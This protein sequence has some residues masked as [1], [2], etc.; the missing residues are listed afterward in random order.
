MAKSSKKQ[1]QNKTKSIKDAKET[2][3]KH[4]E[5]K[6]EV[7]KRKIKEDE[8]IKKIQKMQAVQE[9]QEARD[10]KESQLVDNIKK[11]DKKKPSDP[12]QNQKSDTTSETFSDRSRIIYRESMD[13]CIIGIIREENPQLYKYVDAQLK[14]YATDDANLITNSQK[15]L[16]ATSNDG[17]MASSPTII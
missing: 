1:Q 15:L 12:V 7:E 4:K 2:T 6:E 14:R 17:Q 16:Y 11:D 10:I 13:D 3:I 5:S 9:A 8:D